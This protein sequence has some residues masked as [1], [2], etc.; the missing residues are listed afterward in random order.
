MGK[1]EFLR[2]LEFNL[3]ALNETEKKKSITYYEEII[4][5]YIEN[6]MSEE[7][8]VQKVG[9]PGNIAKDLLD[10][11]DS[12]ELKLPSTGNRIIN[13]SLIVLGFPLWGCLLLSVALF[14]FSIYVL[15]WCVPFMAGA[16]CIGFFIASI[17]S[18]IGSPFVMLK[19]VPIGMLQLGA[20]IASLGFS[21]LLGFAAIYLSHIFTHLSK[22]FTKTII[23]LFKKKVVIR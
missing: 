17:V 15:I 9:N 12:I 14:V 16:G 11:N 6:G 19:N 22:K 7:Q 20:G 21:V 18:I 2:Q 5:D 10:S 3:Q 1:E 13:I 8:A 23:A 4:S